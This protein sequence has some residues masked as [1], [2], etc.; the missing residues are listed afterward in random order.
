M[1]EVQVILI[2]VIFLLG[3]FG[4]MSEADL[5]HDELTSGSWRTS[6][7]GSKSGW[8]NTALESG[9]S[10][11]MAENARGAMKFN[12]LG[13]KSRGSSKHAK[14]ASGSQVQYCS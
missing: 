10:K 4:V 1:G 3:L 12:A 6:F 13:T 5:H 8:S 2:G 7:R 11:H 14:L 9:K